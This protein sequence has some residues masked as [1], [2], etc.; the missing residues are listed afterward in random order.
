MF[1][2]FPI[3]GI[4]RLMYRCNKTPEFDFHTLYSLLMQ[5]T[6]PHRNVWIV[7]SNWFQTIGKDF[8][9]YIYS[10]IQ[11]QIL[12]RQ[13][14]SCTCTQAHR[15]TCTYIIVEL[16]SSFSHIWWTLQEHLIVGCVTNIILCW[17][18]TWCIRHGGKSG[19]DWR[20]K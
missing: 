5:C 19:M 4:Y 14:I 2:F 12:L 7:V 13:S 10:E 11:A 20:R 8:N 9:Q 3:C 15:H 17:I 18:Q 1:Y 6:D 16:T